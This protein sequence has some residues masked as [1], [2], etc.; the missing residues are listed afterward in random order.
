MSHKPLLLIVALLVLAAACTQ[1]APSPWKEMKLPLHKGEILPGANADSLRVQYQGTE[2]R[3]DM[4]REFS[5][6][7]KRAGYEFDRDGKEHD[8][9]GNSFSGIFKKGAVE[10][11][12]TITGA[13]GDKTNVTLKRLD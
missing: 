3:D 10:I 8:P 7:L 1:E 9:P 6:R 5:H 2:R 12:L 4:F 11:M 13:G